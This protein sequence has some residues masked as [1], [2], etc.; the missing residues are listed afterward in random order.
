MAVLACSA[1]AQPA[2]AEA[3]RRS[4]EGVA[5]VWVDC[6]GTDLVVE[7]EYKRV[8]VDHRDGT[9]YTIQ[10]KGIATDE[11]SNIWTFSGHYS[12]KTKN[13]GNGLNPTIRHWIDR[14][15]LISQQPDVPNLLITTTAN[16]VTANGDLAAEMYVENVSCIAQ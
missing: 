5:S 16:L 9:N 8:R 3:L 13:V 14:N 12:F 4:G 11:N 15:I 2:S 1:I 6:L 10:Q 7:F